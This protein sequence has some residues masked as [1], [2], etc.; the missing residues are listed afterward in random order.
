M[1][2]LD[3]KYSHR[4]DSPPCLNLNNL[5]VNIEETR[6][7]VSGDCVHTG[8][9][10]VYKMD[11]NL[12]SHVDPEKSSYNKESMGHLIVNLAKAD[13]PSYWPMPIAG[14]TRP[15]NMHVWFSMK[16]KYEKA[17]YALVKD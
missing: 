14:K 6:L 13:T 17:M 7:Q 2:F 9:A 10:V 1:L 5:K 16:E 4:F 12:W 3:I 11:M 15:K 8:S